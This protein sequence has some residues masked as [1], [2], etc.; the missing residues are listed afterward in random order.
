MTIGLL[1]QTIL[2]GLVV[3]SLGFFGFWTIFGKDW[4]LYAF[5]ST[6]IIVFLYMIVLSFIYENFPQVWNAPL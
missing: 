3:I 1:L 2:V 4:L 5:G 6:M